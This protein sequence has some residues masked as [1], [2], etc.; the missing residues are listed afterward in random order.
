MHDIGE[1][2]RDRLKAN[3][4]PAKAQGDSVEPRESSDP[5]E[6]PQQ[7]ITFGGKTICF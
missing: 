2:T 7:S 1:S 3:E 5:P 4:L 6:R